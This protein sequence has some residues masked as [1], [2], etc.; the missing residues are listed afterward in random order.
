MLK[1][2][3]V[4]IKT[5]SLPAKIAQRAEYIARKEER[6]VSDIFRESFRLYEREYSSHTKVKSLE[7]KALRRTI[8]RIAKQGKKIRLSSFIIHD[9]QSH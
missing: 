6:T 4:A 5:I 1:R 8:G 7:W 2:E 3:K 9:R